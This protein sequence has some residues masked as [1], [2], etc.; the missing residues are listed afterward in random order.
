MLSTIVLLIKNGEAYLAEILEAIYSQ[1]ADFD[2]RVIAIDS[3]SRDRS[4]EI[5]QRY[6]ATLV[7]ISPTEFNHGETR[8]LG[9]RLAGAE[10]DF[11]VYL[12]QDA[13]PYDERWLEHLIQPLRADTRVAGVFSRHIPRP[14][15]YPAAVRQLTTRW[16]TGGQSRL[17]KQMPD[18]IQ[19]YHQNRQ[20]YT[21]FSNT[22]SAIRRHVWE[23]IPFRKVNFAEDADWADR[24]L[25]AGYTIVFEPASVVIHSHDYGLVEQFRQNVDH[26]FGMNELFHPPAYRGVLNWVRQF[27]GIPFEVWQDWRFIQTSPYFAGAGIGRKLRWMGH[28][29]MWYTASIVGAWVGAHLHSIPPQLRIYLS[30][31]ERVRQDCEK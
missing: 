3:G 21:Y 4:I 11:V 30:H 5:I 1:R 13:T 25:Q 31:Q 6:P 27:A 29:W 12:T 18:D 24:V 20:F 7:E 15:S 19:E 23:E 8:N 14:G 22:S 28:S 2:F 17:V 26:A 10:S 9:A 16:Q